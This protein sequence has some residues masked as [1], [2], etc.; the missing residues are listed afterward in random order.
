MKY[1]NTEAC[2][3]VDVDC[4]TD[5]RCQMHKWVKGF[6]GKDHCM[7]KYCAIIKVYIQLYPGVTLIMA[8]LEK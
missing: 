2:V 8:C 7:K 4:W 5:A 3:H 1:W 6:I